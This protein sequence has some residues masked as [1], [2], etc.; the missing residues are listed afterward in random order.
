MKNSLLAITLLG[1]IALSS[2]DVQAQAY[3][4]YY[5]PYWDAIQYQQY[6]QYQQDLAYSQQY[7]PYSELHVMHYQLYR[8]SHS[9]PIYQPCCYTWGVPIL[10][11][12]RPI[13]PPPRPV[14]GSRSRTVVGSIPAV[15]PLPRAVT[16]MPR[17]TGRR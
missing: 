14:I 6:L 12:P 13:G 15:T 16:P 2:R 3:G 7:D 9:Y 5:Y 11:R 17:A 4:P 10:E 1:L 8:P